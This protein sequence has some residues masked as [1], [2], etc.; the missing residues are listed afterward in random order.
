MSDKSPI[1]DV[2]NYGIENTTGVTGVLSRLWRTILMQAGFTPTKYD[3]S[4]R[5]A[6]DRAKV[7]LSA[8]KSGNNR[9]AKTMSVA[10]LRRE[11]ESPTMTW[12]VFIKG[13]RVLKVI[14]FNLSVKL[15]FSTGKE[16]VHEVDIDL[17]K[18]IDYNE[19]TGL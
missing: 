13:L 4:L 11:L 6:S 19:L 8:D 12:K 17:G 18:P 5:N 15:T 16:T 10:N 2:R 1:F 9:L 14:K 3:I 7:Q